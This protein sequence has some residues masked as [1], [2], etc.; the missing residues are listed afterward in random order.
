MNDEFDD[1]LFYDYD[2]YRIFKK[3]KRQ[4]SKLSHFQVYSYFIWDYTYYV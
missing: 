3:K 2:L 4:E 1:K